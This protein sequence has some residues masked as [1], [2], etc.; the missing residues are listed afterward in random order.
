[1]TRNKKKT[2]VQIF[3]KA[4]SSKGTIKEA[5]SVT[6]SHQLQ[7][8][9]RI[10]KCLLAHAS[11]TKGTNIPT[12]A[13]KKAKCTAPLNIYPSGRPFRLVIEFPR[14]RSSNASDKRGARESQWYNILRVPEAS[15]PET[16]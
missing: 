4:I 8:V 3:H 6:R 15:R 5:S 2:I 7:T 11:V 13:Y 1:M 9:R 12:L 14:Q 16:K 10:G